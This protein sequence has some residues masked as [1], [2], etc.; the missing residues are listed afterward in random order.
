MCLLKTYSHFLIVNY[1]L[2]QITHSQTFKL[3]IQLTSQTTYNPHSL[4]KYI[5]LKFTETDTFQKRFQFEYS[6]KSF[7]GTSKNTLKNDL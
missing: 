4:V 1:K 6:K 3:I 2:I 7:L 5:F